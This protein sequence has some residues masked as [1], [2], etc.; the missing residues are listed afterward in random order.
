MLF[1]LKIFFFLPGS[2]ISYN[3][4]K[5]AENF[6]EALVSFQK[7]KQDVKEVHVVIFDGTMLTKFLAA[8]EGCL[9][10]YDQ[11]SHGMLNKIAGW[12]GFGNYINLFICRL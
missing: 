9:Q 11:K 1:Q 2:G 6:F 3:L 8:M 12:M 5:V 4:E 7:K 10:Q